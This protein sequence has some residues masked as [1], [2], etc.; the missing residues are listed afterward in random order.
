VPILGVTRLKWEILEK[1]EAAGN[2]TLGAQG[3]PMGKRVKVSYGPEMVDGE[4]VDFEPLAERW[5]EYRLS[6]GTLVKMKLVVSK[7]V[8]LEKWNEQGEPIYLVQSTNVLATTVPPELMKG[9]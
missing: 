3:E 9:H 7:V 8:R 1:S 2:Q 4:E 5:N 6:D